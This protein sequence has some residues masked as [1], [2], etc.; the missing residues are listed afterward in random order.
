MIK[1]GRCGTSAEKEAPFKVAV[2]K[3]PGEILTLLLKRVT[4]H[5]VK[6]KD[7]NQI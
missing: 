2:G 5:T 6:Q 1:E 4:E 7:L 3:Q